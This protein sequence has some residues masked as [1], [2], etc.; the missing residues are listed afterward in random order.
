M[1]P[2]SSAQLTR[3]EIRLIVDLL[4]ARVKSQIVGQQMELVVTDAAKD[5]II[6]EGLRP[7][8]RCAAAAA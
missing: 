1:P 2:S 4:L 3:E 8:V 6:D 7:G 5:A